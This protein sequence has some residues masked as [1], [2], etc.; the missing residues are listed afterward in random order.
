MITEEIV[1]KIN[2]TKQKDYELGNKPGKLLTY[3][4]KK[5]QVEKTIKAIYVSENKTTYHPQEINQTFFNFYNNLYKS[6]ESVSKDNLEDYLGKIKLP[7][8]SVV[9]QQLLNP[10]QS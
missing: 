2:L 9:D 10:T 5:E 6:Q 1:H 8:V 7:D 4:I 3:Q